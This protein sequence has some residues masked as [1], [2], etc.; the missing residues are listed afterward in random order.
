MR[1]GVFGGS[2]DPIHLGHLLVA[3]D[4]KRKLK[5]ERVLFIPTFQPPHRTAPLAPYHHR[6]TMVQ[7]AIKSNPLFTLSRIEENQPAPSYTIHTLQNLAKLS[8]NY[9]LYLIIGYD[10]Y[11]T[12]KTWYRSEE[13]TELARLVVVSRPGFNQ[14]PLL[15]AHN[16]HQV[17]F[18]QVIPVA[19]AAAAI[20]ARIARGMSIRYLVPSKVADYIYQHRLYCPAQGLVSL[21]AE[22]SGVEESL[23]EFK[24]SNQKRR[25]NV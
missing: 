22:G 17:I 11:W 7:L 8:P 6:Q 15:P 4:V 14:P 2:F 16:R 21:R 3:D 25:Q 24:Y 13:I 1:V 12:M 18:L 9:R 10:Q 19:I 5:L 23:V 20:R